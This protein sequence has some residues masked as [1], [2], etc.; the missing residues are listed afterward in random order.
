MFKGSITAMITP[1]KNGGLDEDAFRKF[2]D[3][4]VENGT[5]G[6]VPCGT[7]GE[8][9]T[10]SHQEHRRVIE[11]CI[12]QN[13]NRIPVIA[14]TGS[15]NT[16]EAIDLTRHAKE[17]GADAA[18]VVTP[19]YNKPSQEG[20]YRHFASIAEQV[21]GLPIVIYNIPGRSIVDMTVE[22]MARLAKIANIVGVKDATSDLVRPID[23]RIAIGP[24]FCQLSGEDATILPF[25]V[26]GG[27]GCI[28]V[29]SNIAPRLCSDLHKAWQA[30][31][32][33][34]AMRLNE[35]LIPLHHAMFCEP[36]PGPAKYAASL[37][38]LCSSDV[39]LP[40][41]DISEAAKERV[42]MALNHTGLLS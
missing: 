40:L 3:F 36:S 41:C 11:I 10:L 18:L 37:L 25:L 33:A 29:T 38:G 17:C 15:N 26:Q 34:E 23:T 42:R 8:S 19:Y 14:G 22:T 24:D 6:L 28:S 35:R 1:F 13:N 32:L 9:P 21:D 4:Q 31:D 30:G 27:V 20:L 7:T 12:E 2:V 16:A 5:F 39:R